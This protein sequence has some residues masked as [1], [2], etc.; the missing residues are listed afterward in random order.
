[1]K[2]IFPVLVYF[3]LVNWTANA[4]LAAGVYVTNIKCADSCTGTAV[5]NVTGG[6]PPY[7]YNWSTGATSNQITQICAGEISVTV[8][9][10]VDSIVVDSAIIFQ[11]PAVAHVFITANPTCNGDINGLVDVQITGGTQ[12]YS[13]CL[14]FNDTSPQICFSKRLN[15]LVAI[16]TYFPATTY[17]LEIT[18]ANGCFSYDSVTLTDPPPLVFD[19]IL[20][21]RQGTNYCNYDLKL[22]ANGGVPPYRYT[23]D[24][25]TNNLLDSIQN[26]CPGI[27]YIRV[28]DVNGC[29]LLDTV[30]ICQAN[31]SSFTQSICNG[32]TV[33]IGNYIHTQT[34]TYTDTLTNITGCDSI[35]TLNLTVNNRDTINIFSGL[36][37][38]DSV[39]F[40]GR[41]IDSVGIYDTLLS[42]GCDTLVILTLLTQDPPGPTYIYDTICANNPILFNGVYVDTTGF[43]YAHYSTGTSCDSLVILQLTVNPVPVVTL[44]WDSLIAEDNV[45]PSGTLAAWNGGSC[46]NDP[47]IFGLKEGS[48]L[49]GTYSGE[50]VQ[51]NIIDFDSVLLYGYSQPDDRIIYTYNDTNGCSASAVDTIVIHFGC[52]GINTINPN[53]LFTLYPNPAD[54]YVMI[55][56]DAAYTGSTIF[57][58]DITGRQL[59]QTKLTT[60]PQQLPIGNLPPGVYLVTL[61]NNG[62]MGARLLVKE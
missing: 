24:D 11:P 57:I 7:Y 54:D 29:F 4:Q 47:V 16:P 44:S 15:S 34:G 52:Q 30:V 14:H 46:G 10:N 26:K 1:M 55:D 43:Y 20:I 45:S 59:L 19:T 39:Y 17:Y 9:D 21:S 50:Y 62:Q 35:V 32:D 5:M 12:P 60:S 18:D 6:V 33:Y 13:F 25:T 51:N 8:T 42:G 41:Y 56:F 27:H 23:W 49:G 38:G 40:Y 2:R 37:S 36:C 22:L 58:K 28:T 53:S 61:Y 3:L 31:S 48:P